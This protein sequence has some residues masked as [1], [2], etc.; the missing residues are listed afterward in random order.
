MIQVNCPFLPLWKPFL[1]YFSA[2]FCVVLVLLHYIGVFSPCNVVLIAVLSIQDV[3]IYIIRY[4]RK[5][6]RH[7]SV[8]SLGMV[9]TLESLM[10]K[11]TSQLKIIPCPRRYT[12]LPEKIYLLCQRGYTYY[13][14]E[15]ILTLPEKYIFLEMAVVL[16]TL[17]YYTSLTLIDFTSQIICQFPV[18]LHLL[19][20][21]FLRRFTMLFSCY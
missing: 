1:L 19:C 9:L 12:S 11:T 10:Q 15:D 16:M 21:V 8:I 20:N 17:S 6:C 7:L 13:A 2:Y 4:S 3:A 18:L 14:R 5:S